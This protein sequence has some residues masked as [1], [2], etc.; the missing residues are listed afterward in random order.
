MKYVFK[1]VISLDLFSL[2]VNDID[3]YNYIN[4]IDS[5]YVC[6]KIASLTHCKWNSIYLII[7]NFFLV[8]ALVFFVVFLLRNEYMHFLSVK[9]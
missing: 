3:F 4:R 7:L 8:S 9:S 2:C 1:F 5:C 6:L